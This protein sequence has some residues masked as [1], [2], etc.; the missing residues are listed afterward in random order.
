MNSSPNFSA[1]AFAASWPCWFHPKSVGSSGVS[2]AILFTSAAWAMPP[3]LSASSETCANVQSVFVVIARFL[4][5]SVP[6]Y[7]RLCTPRMLRFS[8]EPVR[9]TFQRLAHRDQALG[10]QAAQLGDLLRCVAEDTA[11][12]LHAQLAGLGA[13]GHVG[14]EVAPVARCL[15]QIRAGRLIDVEA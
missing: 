6:T 1:T 13:L 3:K 9:S 4:P 11:A 10:A 2:T 7:S 14:A 15:V 8:S 5:V 12:G